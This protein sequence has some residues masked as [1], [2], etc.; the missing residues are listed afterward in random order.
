MIAPTGNLVDC[1]MEDDAP[2]DPRVDTGPEDKV[3][4]RGVE[5]ND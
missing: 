3:V 4:G 1:D 5:A 2:L